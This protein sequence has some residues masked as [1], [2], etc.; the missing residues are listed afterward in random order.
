MPEVDG[1]RDHVTIIE[2]TP[3]YYI[4]RHVARLVHNMSATVRL[5]V[6]VRDPVTRALS[7]YA[8]SISHHERRSNSNVSAAEDSFEERAFRYS[9]TVCIQ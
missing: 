1:H 2:K 6:V 5:L 4:G 8:Q 7:D 3:S 9:S